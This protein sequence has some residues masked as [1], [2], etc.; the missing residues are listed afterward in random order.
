MSRSDVTNI[1]IGYSG[2]LEDLAVHLLLQEITYD[3]E[4]TDG[5]LEEY[6]YGRFGDEIIEAIRPLGAPHTTIFRYLPAG[7]FSRE[8]LNHILM[9]IGKLDSKVMSY[10]TRESLSKPPMRHEGSDI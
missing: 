3:Q 5:R 6:A 7:A 4:M 8:C 1:T 2:S 10:C 9:S